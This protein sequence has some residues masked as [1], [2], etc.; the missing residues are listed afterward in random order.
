MIR[1]VLLIVSLGAGHA[2]AQDSASVPRGTVSDAMTGAAAVGETAAF[3]LAIA[4]VA[5]NEAS[6]SASRADVALIYQVARSHGSSDTERLAWLR[7]HSSCVLTDR[8]R[9]DRERM[10]N[11]V[12][13]RHLTDSDRRPHGW[14]PDWPRW[15]TYLDRWRRIRRWASQLVTGEIADRPCPVDP[16]TWGGRRIDMAQALRRGLRPVG[17]IGT[18]NEGFVSAGGDA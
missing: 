6:L 5:A 18:V 8:P 7:S 16:A 15:R 3:S 13:S 17:C 4:Q 11:C 1:H 2:S 9:T 14:R 12:W 10:T